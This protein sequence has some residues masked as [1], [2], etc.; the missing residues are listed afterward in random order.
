MIIDSFIISIFQIFHIIINIYIWIIIISAL[1]SWVNPDPYNP[2]VQILYK[3]SYPAYVLARKI[4]AR[5]GNI[6][7]APLFIVL[8]LN[9]LD[10]FL[11]NIVRG[12]L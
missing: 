8:A 1:L 7:L 2:I 12:I 5:I 9:F 10:I 4:P 11:Q 6:D 3:L